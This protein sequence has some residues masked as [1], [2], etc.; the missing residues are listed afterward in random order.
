MQ[1]G[2]NKEKQS[3]M[4]TLKNYLDDTGEKKKSKKNRE[5]AVVTY[6][7]LTAFLCLMGYFVYFQY[8]QSEQFINNPYNKRQELFTRSVVRGEIY[9]ADGVTLAETLVDE[10]GNET[11]VYPYGRIFAHVVGYSTHGRSGIEELANFSLLRSNI[12]YVEKAVNQIQGEKSP[13]DSVT[14]TLEYDLQLRAFDALGTYDGAVVVMEPETGKILAMVS[15]PDFDPNYIV[16][17]WDEMVAEDSDSS[18]LLNRATQGLYPPGSTFKIFTTLAYIQQNADYADYRYQCNGKYTFDNKTIHCHKNKSHGTEDL[19]ESFAH[20]CNSSYASLGMTL[21]IE[22]F[23]ELCDSMLFNTA[24]PIAFE[25]SQSS[26]VLSPEDSAS[27]IMET[28]IGQG[29]TL[30]TPFHMALIT[31]AIANDGVLM[32]PYVID[33]TTD[34]EGNLVEQYEPKAYGTMLSDTDAA[35]LQEYMRAVVEEGTAT[36]LLND[37]YEVYG[38]TGSAE[39]SS[40]S[41][42]SHSWFVGYAHQEGKADIAVAI[43]VENSGIGSEYAVPIAQEIFDEYYVEKE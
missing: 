18:A 23:K 35:I 12:L 42:S 27:T 40:N 29:K 39:F 7:F 14:T 1:N 9:S 8:G 24:L 25:S 22:K 10:D 5:F 30:V 6:S 20:S 37:N 26:F 3:L 11:R 36:K 17:E 13:G 38:K 19:K 33:Y 28:A 41:N 34:D 15:K 21:D 32:R 16:E 4:K 31:S 2:Q 43:I